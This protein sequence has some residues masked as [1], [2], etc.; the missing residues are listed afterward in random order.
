MKLIF[1]L[2]GIAASAYLGYMLE[3]NLRFVLTGSQ[4]SAIEKG[5]DKRVILDMPGNAP[6]IDLGSL[7]LDQL[8]AKLI[9]KTAVDVSDTASG[10][11]MT[12]KAG[13]RVKLLRIEGAN[14]V[15][16][17]GE[18]PFSGVLAITETDLFEQLATT[19]PT[20]KRLAVADPIVIPQEPEETESV[21][22]EKAVDEPQAPVTS[23]PAV[24][25]VTEETPAAAAAVADDTD[26]TGSTDVV[27]IMQASI[28]SSQIKE[29]TFEKVLE[30]QAGGD[31]VVN[32]ETFKTGLA[33]YKAET[34]F[35]TKTIKAKALIK[36]GKVQRWVGENTGKQ[37]K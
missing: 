20:G 35:G 27:E 2:F 36:G 8:P 10:T 29:F 21:K 11:T 25:E 19:P 31:E 22:P 26:T 17:P 14:A 3:P 6:S 15:V 4:P 37:L 12:M 28:K 18:G 13:S 1:N 32:G 16:S 5:K 33:S 34:I 9:I 24:E 7:T 30:W 23:E